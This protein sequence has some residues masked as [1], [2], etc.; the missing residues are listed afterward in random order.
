[1]SSN[2]NQAIWTTKRSLMEQHQAHAI[3]ATLSIS[4]N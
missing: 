3:R 4:N 2:W 1:L